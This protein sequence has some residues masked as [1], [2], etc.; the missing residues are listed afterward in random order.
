MSAL[1]PEIRQIVE[2]V[3]DEPTQ[4]SLDLWHDAVIDALIQAADKGPDPRP[5]R[6]GDLERAYCP[7]C[8][9]GASTGGLGLMGY[10]IPTGLSDHLGHRG[11]AWP[12]EVT[13]MIKDPFRFRLPPA[14][15]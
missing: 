5:H 8:G 10:A 7:L 15:E 9:D 13:K 4:E 6:S 11:R 3:P 1:P 12:C 14:W 2:G